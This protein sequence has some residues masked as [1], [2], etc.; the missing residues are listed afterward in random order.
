VPATAG[1]GVMILPTTLCRCLCRCL[2]LWLWLWLLRRSFLHLGL[3][4]TIEGERTFSDPRSATNNPTTG[5]SRNDERRDNTQSVGGKRQK[6]LSVT[7]R[8]G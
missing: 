1:V 2:W 4:V 5:D 3:N 6:L 8:E 7:R